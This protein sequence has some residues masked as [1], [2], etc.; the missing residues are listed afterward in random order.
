MNDLYDVTIVGAGSSGSALATALAKNNHDGNPIRIALIEE[1]VIDNDDHLIQSDINNFDPRVSALTVGS[2][3]FLCDIGVWSKISSRRLCGFKKMIVW[4]SLGS[5]MVNFDASHVRQ[6]FLGYIVENKIILS[7]L[8]EKV[9]SLP[10]IDIYD[11]QSVSAFDPN[12]RSNNLDCCSIRLTNGKEIKSR[13]LVAAD[14]ANSRM[15]DMANHKTRQWEYFQDAIV[16]TI[17]LEKSHLD[18]AWQRFTDSGPIALLPLG[19]G[20]KKNICSLVW[21]QTSQKADLIYSMNNKEFCHELSCFLEKRFGDVL[22]CSKRYKFKLRHCHS[23]DYISPKF[24][25]V[26]DAAH[27]IHPLAGQGIN[28]GLSDVKVLSRLLLDAHHHGKDLSNQKL[29]KKYQRAA[30]T[31]NFKM[32]AAIE[33]LKKA[34]DPL[35]LPLRWLRNFGMNT[36]NN[37]ASIKKQIM[38]H[39]MGIK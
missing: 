9:L 31:N 10:M 1:K 39:A 27:S 28:M 17:K 5:G 18:T 36:F 37:Q 3:K 24:V 15:R 16:C 29:L 23:V 19:S 34:F 6:P 22:D 11:Q 12:Y 7:A 25:L 35:P 32:I 8:H 33:T 20:E 14:G 13:L 26:A 30:K 38:L 4:D 2:K 21:S